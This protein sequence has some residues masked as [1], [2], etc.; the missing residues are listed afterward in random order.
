[1]N[2]RKLLFTPFLIIG[3]LIAQDE[4]KEKFHFEF[5]MDSLEMNVG[6]SKE[7]T[8]KLLNAK[9]E[10]AQILFMFMAK[11]NLYQYHHAS[12]IPLA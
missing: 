2:K 10:L 9:G 3:M 12:A 8:I 11:E 6:E 5:A 4:N 7:V 1:M